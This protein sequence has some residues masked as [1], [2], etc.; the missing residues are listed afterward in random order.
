VGQKRNEFN[1]AC[2]S[3]TIGVSMWGGFGHRNT[4]TFLP[5]EYERTIS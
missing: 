5:N 2:P 4:T 1:D 3:F